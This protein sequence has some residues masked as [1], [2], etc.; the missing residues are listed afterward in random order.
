[1]LSKEFDLFILAV[2]NVIRYHFKV[3]AVYHKE[4]I[5]SYY[6]KTCTFLKNTKI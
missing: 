4:L 2:V 5:T 1:V 3:I 6:I